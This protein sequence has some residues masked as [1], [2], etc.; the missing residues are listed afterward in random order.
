MSQT[1]IV[2]ERLEDQLTWYDRASAH[3]KLMYKGFKTLKIIIG[4]L[5]PLTTYFAP[6][7]VVPAALGAALVVFE[8]LHELNQ[9]ERNWLAYRSTAEA[10]KHEKYLFLSTVGVYATAQNPKALLAERI[11]SLISQNVGRQNPQ[12]GSAHSS[13]SVN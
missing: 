3:N 4:A 5:V 9:Y 1:D 13:P 7:K 12:I 6:Y 10:L 2:L 8:S 11:E